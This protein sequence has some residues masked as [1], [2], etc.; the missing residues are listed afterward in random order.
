MQ[1]AVKPGRKDTIHGVGDIT[2]GQRQGADAAGDGGR[3][4]L[5]SELPAFEDGDVVASCQGCDVEGVGDVELGTGTGEEGDQAPEK[6]MELHGGRYMLLSFF[7]LSAGMILKVIF[8]LSPSKLKE[9][10]DRLQGCVK[11]SN[12]PK[13]LMMSQTHRALIYFVDCFPLALASSFGAIH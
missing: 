2:D 5:G 11:T 12:V 6:N 7:S 4:Q 13:Q 10:Y 3:C 1:P 8:L 9:L